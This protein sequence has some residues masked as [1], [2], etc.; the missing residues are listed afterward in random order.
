[1]WLR[2]PEKR[3]HT[4]PGSGNA[5]A[6][7]TSV[8]TRLPATTLSLALVRIATPLVSFPETRLPSCSSSIPS[9]SVPIKLNEALFIKVIPLVFGNTSVPSTFVP[10]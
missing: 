3:T 10:T 6:P 1:M 5:F 4:P 2:L 8:P 7:V 9:P